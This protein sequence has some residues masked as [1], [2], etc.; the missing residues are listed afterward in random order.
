MND[1]HALEPEHSAR[2]RTPMVKRLTAGQRGRRTY[3]AQVVRDVFVDWGARIGA[4]WILVL[5]VVAVFAPLLA[6]SIPLLLSKNGAVSSPVLE[7][8]TPVDATLLVGFFSGL[9]LIVLPNVLRA[10]LV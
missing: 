6:N 3:A 10:K 2:M 5:V 9:V 8:V 7:Y 1:G 4:A